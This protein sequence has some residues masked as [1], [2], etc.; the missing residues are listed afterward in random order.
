MCEHTVS[1]HPLPPKTADEVL[2]EKEKKKQSTGTE[3]QEDHIR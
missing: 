2:K 3:F 1:K